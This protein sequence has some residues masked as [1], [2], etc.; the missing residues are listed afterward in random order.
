MLASLMNAVNHPIELTRPSVGVVSQRPTGNRD[1]FHHVCTP[2][3]PC[4]AREFTVTT[5]PE[6][7][8]C[9]TGS[10]HIGQRLLS[11]GMGIEPVLV[12][13]VW[14]LVAQGLVRPDSLVE[15]IPAEEG[16]LQPAQIG[17]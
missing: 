9:C 11:H 7:S 5:P 15:V 8:I 17:G 2:V 13:L 1:G 6:L 10:G 3:K 14:G 16:C 12:E 4:Q